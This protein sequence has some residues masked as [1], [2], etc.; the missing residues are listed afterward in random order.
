MS[1]A[2]PS[3]AQ[4]CSYRRSLHQAVQVAVQVWREHIQ[5]EGVDV[6]LQEVDDLLHPAGR[7]QGC[8]QGWHPALRQPGISWNNS[9]GITQHKSC[10]KGS[11]L[12]HNPQQQD[13]LP[14]VPPRLQ[15]AQ[16][17]NS[18]LEAELLSPGHPLGVSHGHEERDQPL[19]TESHPALL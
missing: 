10:P 5:V 6:S 7:A 11:Q 3:P 9:A 4:P 19:A 14:V 16:G 18:W 15:L 17:L 13:L 1:A 12:L 8:C 2:L